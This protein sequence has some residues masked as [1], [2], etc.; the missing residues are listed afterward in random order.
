VAINAAGVFIQ[1]AQ[2]GI[3]FAVSCD[4][5]FVPQK[6]RIYTLLPATRHTLYRKLCI[7][8]PESHAVVITT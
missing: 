5:F 7:G 6:G 8:V 3:R 2:I 4:V 1:L